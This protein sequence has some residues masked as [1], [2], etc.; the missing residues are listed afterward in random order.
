MNNLDVVSYK[1]GLIANYI[2]K[3]HMNYF[4]NIEL[5]DHVVACQN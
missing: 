5:V 1:N 3:N 2:W 4:H